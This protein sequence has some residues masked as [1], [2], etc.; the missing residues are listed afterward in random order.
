MHL[1]TLRLYSIY[2]PYEEP[3]RLVPTLVMAAREGKLPPLVRPTIS[4]DFVYVDDAVEA[5]VQAA[6]RPG[7]EPG[8]VYNVGSGVRT[9]LADLVAV[10]RRVFELRVEPA[11]GSMDDR[12]WDTDVWVSDPTLIRQALGW[13]ARVGLEAGLR[14]TAA[15][16]SETPGMLDRYR[17]RP[18]GAR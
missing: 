13:E 18:P 8:V 11:W 7:Q 5:F 2:G 4:R 6:S 3:S 1:P 15:F 17:G 10:A 12:H 16:L 9:T 14:A